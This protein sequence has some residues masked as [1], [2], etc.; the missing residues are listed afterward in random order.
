MNKQDFIKGIKKMRDF[1]A[2]ANIENYQDPP[3]RRPR[4][5]DLALSKFY[6]SLSEEGKDFVNQIVFD[7]I[8]Q[9]FF[10]FF[11][12]LDHVGFI[13]DTEEKSEFELYAIKNGERVLINDPQQE[14][15]HNLYNDL[16]LDKD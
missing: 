7:S 10:S 5:K 2:Q 14:E 11:C 16:T 8:D 15:L 1:C 4:D 6:C 3:G 13:E 12:V 9:A